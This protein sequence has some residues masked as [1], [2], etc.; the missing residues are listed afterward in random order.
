MS[1]FDYCYR[2]NTKLLWKI[3]KV[4]KSVEGESPP[5]PIKKYVVFYT[6]QKILSIK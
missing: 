4:P 3:K 6:F 1:N 5:P 2:S